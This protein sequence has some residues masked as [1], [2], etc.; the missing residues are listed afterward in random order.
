MIPDFC[1]YYVI[2]EIFHKWIT[3]RTKYLYIRF[4]HAGGWFSSFIRQ[5][6]DR[7]NCTS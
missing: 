5:T 4:W 2:A 7:R 3:R 6:T 1:P